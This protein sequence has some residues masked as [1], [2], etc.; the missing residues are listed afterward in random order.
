M[1]VC[2]S[3]SE[4]HTHTSAQSVGPSE[5]PAL[6]DL[7]ERREHDPDVV[8]VALLRHH[9]DEQLP[10][11]NRCRRRREAETSEIEHRKKSKV[12]FY[13]GLICILPTGVETLVQGGGRFKD[14]WTF[15]QK[16]F[17]DCHKIKL[18]GGKN[19]IAGAIKS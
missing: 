7:S 19:D 14:L 3:E 9:A 2:G 6:L 13:G 1:C 4:R 15:R 8:L 16:S 18:K 11:F 5:D 17:T 12:E 10:V